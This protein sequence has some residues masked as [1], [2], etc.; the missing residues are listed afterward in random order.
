MCNSRVPLYHSRAINRFLLL[1]NL[2]VII[3]IQMRTL[4]SQCLLTNTRDSKQS[5]LLL[6]SQMILFL[7]S[8]VIRAKKEE[9]V[10]EQKIKRIH[11]QDNLW[12]KEGITVPLSQRD[13]NMIQ[14]KVFLL[15]KCKSFRSNMK[16]IL[17]LNQVDT[18]LK[19]LIEFPN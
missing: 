11:L 10:E 16:I 5:K 13:F 1:G 3:Q 18:I 12:E 2:D 9:L 19:S 8:W 15:Q 7:Q 6:I 4:I 14:R 17:Q